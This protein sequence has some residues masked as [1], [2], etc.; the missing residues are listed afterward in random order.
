VQVKAIGA[1]G[2][3]VRF[4]RAPGGA[5]SG[6]RGAEEKPYPG[7]FFDVVSI[8]DVFDGA[9]SAELGDHL[10][11]FGLERV[12]P[13]PAVT[14]DAEGADT[15]AA[16]AETVFA[17]AV[18][19]DEEAAR[20]LTSARDRAHGFGRVDLTGLHSS[21]GLAAQVIRKAGVRPPLLK[22]KTPD[23]GELDRWIAAHRGGW[24]SA[25]LAGAGLFPAVDID[26]RSAYPAVASLVHWWDVVTAAH[27][28]R[29]DV[30]DE[31]LALCAEAAR[32]DVSRLLRPST[33]RRLGLTLCEVVPD[34]ESWPVESADE[35]YPEGHAGM[36]PVRSSVALP[37]TWPDVVLAALRAGRVPKVLWAT[38][39]VPVGRQQGLR[40]S[41]SLYAGTALQ[42]G[43]D[44]AVSLVHLRDNAKG[45]GDD[46]LA[47]ML[48]VLV[49]SLVYGNFA[50][51]DPVRRRD[52]RRVVLGEQPFEFT[53]PPIAATVTAGSRLLVGIAE[54]LVEEAGGTIAGRD[55]DGLLVW[56]PQGGAVPV[57]H[58]RKAGAISWAA[59]DGVLA[60]F[61]SL[62]PWGD[63]SSFWKA[64]VREHNGHS[65]H[66]LVIGV[67]RYALATLDDKG[68]LIEVV[69]A[70]EHAL[71]G[72]V[73]DPP[74]FA[75]RAGDGRH[76]WTREVAAFAFRQAVAG[77]RGEQLLASTWPGRPTGRSRPSNAARSSPR[78]GL[79]S[80][81]VGFHSSRPAATCPAAPSSRGT[82]PRW[83]LIPE[84]TFPNGGTSTGEGRTA[85][86]S[87]RP[88]VRATRPCGTTTSGTSCWRTSAG[89]RPGGCGAVRSTTGWRS[90]SSPS[91]F[92]E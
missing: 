24:L 31:V 67:K 26:I 89:R 80:C 57:L 25:E 81:R 35:D 66:G 82:L 22:F 32:G 7:R 42:L 69:E 13:P 50:R 2:Y 63:G 79:W 60:R 43:E 86:R 64:P 72:S 21:G 41:W 8:A 5:G 45:E 1:H 74:G 36:R 27:L 84:V 9:D 92:A 91:C 68:D 30:L 53:Y 33:W 37:F 71:G 49:N 59:L 23:D 83:R 34:G 12:D 19:L 29:Q 70:T 47:A 20:W 56:S 10:D 73:V 78:S 28:R 17:L 62:D 75:G 40:P 44:P 6:K 76:R 61:D 38:K 15:V 11:A 46:R 90:S 85:G 77:S 88:S 87:W 14:L 52:G 16:A 51:L 3:L 54:H 4:A 39:L 18:C 58:G 55:T 48:R 65:L